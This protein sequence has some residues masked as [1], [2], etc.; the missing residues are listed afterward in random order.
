MQ[1]LDPLELVRNAL[2][3]PRRWQQRPPRVSVRVRA[4]A[5]TL[6]RGSA[7]L[8]LIAGLSACT[9]KSNSGT[10]DDERDAASQT[11][12]GNPSQNSVNP[13]SASGGDAGS[14]ASSAD[15]L[16]AASPTDA[17]APYDGPWLGALFAHTPIMSEMDWPKEERRRG[18]HAGA[19]EG[20]HEIG[21]LRR[22]QKVPV[23]AR[24]HTRANCKEGW[25]ELVQGGYVC[26]KHGSVDLN[27]PRFR[28]APSGPNLE[29]MLPFKYGYNASNG[30]PQYR[31]VPS[32]EERL[33]FEPWLTAKKKPKTK[34]LSPDTETSQPPDKAEATSPNGLILGR[35][36]AGSPASRG[37]TEW[38]QDVA[39]NG[40]E[41]GESST[42][43]YLRDYDGGKPQVSLDELK[44]EGPM[45]SRMVKGFY[46]SLDTKVDNERGQPVWWST[47]SGL[48]V[49]FER[50]VLWK[51]VSVFQGRWFDAS[52]LP[53]EGRSVEASGGPSASAGSSS[54]S[55]A[56][57]TSAP[58][59]AGRETPNAD[60]GSGS[61]AATETSAS[62]E[63]AIVKKWKSRKYTL[64]SSRK[65]A[66]AGDPIARRTIVRLT[67]ERE[68]IN[69]ATY[70]LTDEGWWVLSSD[71]TRLRPGKPPADLAPGEK[72]VDVNTTTQTLVAFEG[73]KPVFATA[74]STGKVDRTDKEKD[75]HTKPGLF[76][77][78]TKHVSATM[79]ADSADGAY[80]IQ[81]VPWVMYF[82]GGIALHGAFWHDDF[83][84]PR[85]HGC[86]NLAPK[87][88]KAIFAW[89]EPR[90]PQGW[91]GVDATA[92]HPGTRVIVHD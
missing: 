41:G 44:G 74:V 33:A 79:D 63:I 48:L 32:R 40:G 15:A 68:T 26:G 25:Y 67:G 53:P 42:P 65:A 34:S 37:L 22:G 51:T 19:R 54:T 64:S 77:I 45:E 52:A 39:S 61:P 69:K 12:S 2:S 46:V 35:S 55:A 70:E 27:H 18:D 76:R 88:A 78:Q 49:P 24:A 59:S 83:G 3:T 91:H 4:R 50:I 72:W 30:T 38:T 47:Q 82:S 81:D 16:D 36:G 58:E 10:R 23:I 62:S 14:A 57:A 8:G 20:A 29:E 7:C 75:H 9:T 84:V 17:S 80:S 31:T 89:S 90:L 73:D 92:E 6:L 56:G 66:I 43:W 60:A 5:S 11:G 13:N 28:L 1:T 71:A 85:S 87:D 21:Y 86:V